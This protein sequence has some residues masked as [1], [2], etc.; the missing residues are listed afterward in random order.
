MMSD[1]G[2]LQRISTMDRRW[3]FLGVAVFVVVPTI[4]QWN[5][6]IVVTD[7]VKRVYDEVDKVGPDNY[8]P[9]LLS[10]DFDPGTM[11][12]LG[13]MAE[14]VLRH[15]F[16]NKGKVIVITFM[17]TGAALARQTLL[18]V[19]EERGAVY[20]EDYLYLGYK[21][22]PG[23]VMLSTGE[24]IRINCPIDE[25]NQKP[26][27]SYPMMKDV[28]NYKDIQ[29]V[30]DLAGNSM[31]EAWITNAWG[32]YG[33]NFTMGVTA[34]MA[35]DYMPFLL[36]GQSKGMLG[37]MRGAAEYEK[38]LYDRG[39]INRKGTAMVGMDPQSAVHFFIVFMIIVG[40]V[41]YFLSRK[42]R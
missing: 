22:P 20:G 37:G 36:A 40:N 16:D 41:A 33:A 13:P 42:G 9:V 15:I 8:K 21:F 17:P 5:L 32:R 29:V 19:A 31:P 26:L 14:A 25:I 27:D 28:K 11:A 12:E 35:P 10:F 1:Q 6:P 38:L 23:A 24:D 39:V 3:I 2:L 18:K 4:W 30:V 7:D 34:V